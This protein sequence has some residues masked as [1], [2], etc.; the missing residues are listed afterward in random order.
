[1]SCARGRCRFASGRRITEIRRRDIENANQF[2]NL[3]CTLPE[4]W[5]ASLKIRKPT[6]EVVSIHV[7]MFG[8]P[9]QQPAKPKRKKPGEDEPTPEEKQQIK[10]QRAMIELLSAPPGT[11]RIAEINRKYTNH[12]IDSW[13]KRDGGEP[14]A[15]SSVLKVVDSIQRGNEVVGKQELWLSTDG[16]FRIDWQLAEESRM[17]LF[18]GEKFSQAFGN[19]PFEEISPAQAKT[20]LPIVQAISLVSML[21]DSGFSSH[22]EA[23]LDGSD[24]ALQKNAYRLRVTGIDGDP[25]FVWLSM[26]DDKTGLPEVR[27]LKAA[28]EQDCDQAGGVTFSQWEENEGVFFPRHREFVKGLEE[29]VFLRLSNQS[30]QWLADEKPTLFEA[31]SRSAGESSETFSQESGKELP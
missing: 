26:Y 13:R 24:K 22:G 31:N 11:V 4:N 27:L 5:P 25:L 3:I 16:K 29:A 10:R 23:L 21:Q 14:D 17:I 12:L 6:G 8:L 2:T 28:S 1:M 30:Q 7:R 20:Q 9:Y 15:E 18:D 19:Q